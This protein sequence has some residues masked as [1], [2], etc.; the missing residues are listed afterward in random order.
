MAWVTLKDIMRNL[1][2]IEKSKT[3]PSTYIGYGRG[4]VFIIT[5]QGKEWRAESLAL[6]LGLQA[7]TLREIS[8]ML[9]LQE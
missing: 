9:A 7:R 8:I 3:K 2:N 5:K 6:R 1:Y 4:G